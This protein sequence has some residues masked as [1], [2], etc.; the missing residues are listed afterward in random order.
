VALARPVS[1][2]EETTMTGGNGNANGSLL[3]GRSRGRWPGGRR[4]A[5]GSDQHRDV[6]AGG[7]GGEEAGGGGPRRGQDPASVAA[8]R[9]ALA[10]G[11]ELSEERQG[12]A[13]TAI[14]YALGV[15]PGAV[16]GALRPRLGGSGAGRGLA[17]G[18]ALF[19]LND[20]GIG[21]ALGLAAGPT[22]YP[23]QAHA[24]G[25]TAHLVLGI[26]TDAVLDLLDRAG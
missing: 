21:P 12:Q 26:A 9:I 20:E 22:A 24:R 8:A 16:Y 1:C 13:A 3:R 10:T 18:L 2:K 19:L 25:L 11:A 17:Y 23:W 4:L 7:R 6:R 14:H 15:V 5:D